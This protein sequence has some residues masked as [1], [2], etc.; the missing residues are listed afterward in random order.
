MF[1]LKPRWPETQ[2]VV[3]NFRMPTE[4]QKAMLFERIQYK[5]EMQLAKREMQQNESGR[6][7]HIIENKQDLKYEEII[8]DIRH[9]FF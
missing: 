1:A 6:M 5:I 2:P 9:A 4:A 7:T 3:F 8:S